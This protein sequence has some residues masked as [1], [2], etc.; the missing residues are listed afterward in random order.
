[1]YKVS[2]SN[3]GNLYCT[4]SIVKLNEDGKLE[5]EKA[6]KVYNMKEP[7]LTLDDLPQE[8]REILVANRDG[9]PLFNHIFPFDNDNQEGE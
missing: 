5:T 3:S 2:R 8:I 1:M 4:I 9:L 6:W 7:L